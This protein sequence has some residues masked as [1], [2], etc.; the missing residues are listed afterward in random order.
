[1]S[2]KRPKQEEIVS[3]LRQVEVLMGQD[4]SLM[5]G[6]APGRCVKNKKRGVFE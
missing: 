6:L 5:A 3:T 4:I 1:M 2:N